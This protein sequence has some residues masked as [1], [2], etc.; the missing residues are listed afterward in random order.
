MLDSS[1][2]AIPLTFA[3]TGTIVNVDDY[4]FESQP[5]KS[6]SNPGY[7]SSLY[8]KASGSVRKI[9]LDQS[10]LAFEGKDML[11]KSSRRGVFPAL[12]FVYCA[13]TPAPTPVPTLAPVTP[14]PTPEPTLAPVTPAPTPEPTLV[15]V[16]PA[17]TP[18]PSGTP[19]G[20]NGDVSSFHGSPFLIF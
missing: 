1:G 19:G 9:L 7:E 2:N 17:P 4:A 14:A 13:D 3:T 15:P 18:P 10:S 16:T 6:T 11:G 5:S 8:A 20:V 12:D